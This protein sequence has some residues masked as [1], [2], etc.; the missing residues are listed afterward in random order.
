MT[1][2]KDRLLGVIERL[3]EIGLDLE[4]E[5]EPDYAA[6]IR[7]ETAIL[8]GILGD[9]VNCPDCAGFGRISLMGVKTECSFCKGTGRR[10]E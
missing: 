2:H 4:D 7:G 9:M 5:L 8:R 3:A 1:A 6:K 10:P